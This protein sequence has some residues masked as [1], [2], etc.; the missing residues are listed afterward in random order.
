MNVK[1]TLRY[2]SA[3]SLITAATA[4]QSQRSHQ[5]LGAQAGAEQFTDFLARFETQTDSLKRNKMIEEYVGKLKQY[6]RPYADGDTIWF[7]YQGAARRVGIPSDL[8]GWNPTID[9]MKRLKGT[10]LFYLKKVIDEAARFEYKLAVDSTWILDPLNKQQAMGGYGPNSEIWM[11]TYSPPKEIEYREAIPHGAVDTFAIKST[12]LKRTHPVFVYTPPGYRKSKQLYPSIYVTDGGEY[13]TL[14]LMLN[15]LDNLI[16]EKRIRPIV[17]IFIDPRTDIKDS[18]TSKRMLDYTMSDTFVNFMI[19]EVRARMI[20]QYRLDLDPVQTAIMGASLGGLIATYAAYTRPDVF[21]LSAAQSPAYQ[22]NDHEMI[23][24]IAAGPKKPIKI[25]IDTGTI[26]DA[27]D[28]AR[29]M[30][31]VLEEEGYLLHYAEYPESHNWVNW[32]ARIDDILT[33]FWGTE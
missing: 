30:K 24:M 11:P 29:R 14:A 16:A 12:L 26:R 6:G 1:S 5:Q 31:A 8:N 15:V 10:N 7:L 22:I 2:I 18:R 4:A 13:I 25:Y 32:R 19:T 33:Y 27:Q 9:T 20:R 3:A 21:G 28:N 17:A 23:K